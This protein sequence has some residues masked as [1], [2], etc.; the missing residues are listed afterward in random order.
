MKLIADVPLAAANEYSILGEMPVQL[1]QLRALAAV[2]GPEQVDL[3]AD[4]EERPDA[5]CYER[6][7]RVGSFWA[8]LTWHRSRN[9]YAAGD[10]GFGSRS[11]TCLMVMA[12]S[13]KGFSCS[14]NLDRWAIF[15]P[16]CFSTSAYPSAILLPF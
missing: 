1:P 15:R 3:V 12:R 7:T 13:D 2:D 14:E 10:S 4:D 8:L 11:S 16:M 9:R 5:R 6:G